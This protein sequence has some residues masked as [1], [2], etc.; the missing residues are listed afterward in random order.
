MFLYF[1][2]KTINANYA[3]DQVMAS[4]SSTYG[5]DVQATSTSHRG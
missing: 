2:C 5:A 1:Y 3:K 4:K